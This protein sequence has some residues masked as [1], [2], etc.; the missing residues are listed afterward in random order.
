MSEAHRNKMKK[1]IACSLAFILIAVPAV[2]QNFNE[3]INSE[4]VTD[5]S[6]FGTGGYRVNTPSGVKVRTGPSAGYRRADGGSGATNG[7]TF[8]VDRIE[9]SWGH[10]TSIST[11]GG[12]N[13]E[14]WVCLSYCSYVGSGTT[15]YVNTSSSANKNSAENMD[16]SQSGIEAICTREGFSRTCYRD[17]TQSSIGYGTR[18]GTSVHNNGLHSITREGAKEAMM[19]EMPTYVANVRRQCAGIQMTQNQFDALVSFTYNSGGGTSMIINSPLVQYLRGKLSESEARSQ[20]SNYVVKSGGKRLEGLV[21]RRNNEAEQFFSGAGSNGNNGSASS[22]VSGGNYIVHVSSSLNIRQNAG[23]GYSVIGRL[24][25][26]DNVNVVGTSGNWAHI[27]SPQNGWV[28]LSYISPTNGGNGGQ[29][30]SIVYGSLANNTTYRI[31]AE[32]A[33]NSCLDIQDGKRDNNTNIQIWENTVGNTNQIFKAVEHNGWYTFVDQQSGKV[34]D[35]SG[36]E[37]VSGRNV[38]LYEYNGTDAQMWKLIDAGNGYY[39]VVSKLDPNNN[40][41]LDVSCGLSNNGTN[42]QVYSANESSAQKFRF[43]AD[44]PTT[45]PSNANLGISDYSDEYRNSQY[46]NQLNSCTRTGANRQTLANI[47]LSQVGFHEGSLNGYSASANNMCEYN[48]WF[49][50]K[51]VSGD[52]YPWCAVFIS[53]CARNAGIAKEVIP[54][55]AAA[56]K[57]GGFYDWSIAHGRYYSS[58]SYSPQV[59]DIAIFTWSH[60]GIVVDVSG[61]TVTVVEGNSSQKVSKYNYKANGKDGKIAGYFVPAY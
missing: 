26:G 43:I 35:V 54:T 34:I 37:N 36:G 44:S 32:C 19:R 38:Q 39:Y 60:V 10:T 50:G 41:R 55:T 48:R 29:A 24:Y 45:S 46:Y 13:V 30:S 59:G 53:W 25:N 31:S 16:I 27:N 42:V 7:T 20:Y 17:N 8:Q 52:A 57:Q 3:F 56:R 14:G 47:A 1:I 21:R 2:N 33:P 4:Y 49:Y 61:N 15:N 18:C 11:C 9:G 58:V 28:S 22:A 23:T 40:L 5:I 51:N 6:A 12:G